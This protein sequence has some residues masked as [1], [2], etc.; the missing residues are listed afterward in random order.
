VS[1]ETERT[2]RELA[3]AS[4]AAVR[5]KDRDG[6]LALFEPDATVEDPVGPSALDPEGRGRRGIEEIAAFYDSVI[7]TMES[8]DYEIERTYLGGAELAMVVVFHIGLGGDQRMDMDLV[9][10]YERSPGGKIASL[11]SFWDGSRQGAQG[12]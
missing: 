9:N 7:S 4:L 10:I 12:A 5:A 1:I 6:W 11:R 2:A 3:E 8:F